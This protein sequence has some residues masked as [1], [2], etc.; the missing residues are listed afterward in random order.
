MSK[1]EIWKAN[2]L[3]FR[4]RINLEITLA[5][6]KRDEFRKEIWRSCAHV[7]HVIIYCRVAD[8]ICVF[9]DCFKRECRASEQK[10]SL[11]K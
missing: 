10:L 3:R 7:C 11:C 5:I 4:L 2:F 1:L 9:R 8:H 6:N